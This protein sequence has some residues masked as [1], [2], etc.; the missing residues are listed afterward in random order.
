[1]SWWRG[2]D[3]YQRKHRWAGIPLGVVYKYGDDQGNYLAALL[4]Y[5]AFL[6]IFPLLLLA[7]TI[8]GFVL[9]NDPDLQAEILDST[10]ARFP[11]IGDQLRAPGGL[12]GSSVAVVIAIL[13]SLYGSLG[14]ANAIQNAVNIAWAVPRNR[15]PNPIMVRVRSVVLLAFSGFAIILTTVIAN[16]RAVIAALGGDVSSELTWPITILTVLLNAAIFMVVFRLASAHDHSIRRDIPGGVFSA[17]VWQ[18]L[19]YV[20]TAYVS[21]IVKDS[22]AVAG[23]FAIV[24]GMLAWIYLGAITV[25]L[26]IEINV[27]VAKKLYPRALLTPFTDNVDLTDADRRVYTGYA[28]AQGHKGWQSVDV[29]FDESLRKRKSAA[30]ATK[31]TPPSDKPMRELPD[32]HPSESA[33]EPGKKPAQESAQ[34]PAEKNH[35]GVS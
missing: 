17:V 6:S 20:G 34:E 22:S 2:V 5:Y 28:Q 3:R 7:S 8:L 21:Q 19:Q 25:V 18:L 11:V 1:M 4:T 29:T 12:Q 16:S 9:Q 32:E 31:S 15:R 33:E 10:L 27:V 35:E 13:T 14:V 23:T 26:G 24:L 30:R